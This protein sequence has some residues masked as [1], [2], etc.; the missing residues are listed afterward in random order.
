MS[1]G[2]Q[3]AANM[4]TDRTR[5][6][7]AAAYGMGRGTIIPAAIFD[8]KDGRSTGIDHNKPYRVIVDPDQ[9]GAFE[10]NMA[11]LTDPLIK[12]AVSNEVD[13]SER[14]RLIKQKL[15]NRNKVEQVEQ[16]EQAPATQPTPY[17]NFPTKSVFSPQSTLQASVTPALVPHTM[18]NTPQLFRIHTPESL[19]WSVGMDSTPHSFSVAPPTLSHR[20]LDLIKQIDTI[21][22]NYDKLYHHCNSVLQQKDE[23]AKRYD[24]LKED[25]VELGNACERAGNAAKVN[26]VPHSLPQ[27]EVVADSILPFL[28]ETARPPKSKAVFNFKQVGTMAALYHKLVVTETNVVLVYDTRFEYGTQYIPPHLNEEDGI[29]VTL[30]DEEG[31]KNMQLRSLGINFSLGCLDISVLFRV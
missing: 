14:L 23:L 20:E 22:Q 28:G 21:R 3:L 1:N 13:L 10:L 31:T 30:I 7:D 25:Y 26:A 5:H 15:D 16:V 17:L 6:H 18:E 29:A 19:P 11:E 4:P 27:A 2:V 24:Q 8:E 12:Q 9:P